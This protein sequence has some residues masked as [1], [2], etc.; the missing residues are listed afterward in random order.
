MAALGVCL[1][2]KGLQ[3]HEADRI[4][5]SNSRKK[6]PL[7]IAR[8]VYTG[9]PLLSTLWTVDFDKHVDGPPIEFF[10]RW[11]RVHVLSVSRW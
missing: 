4:T 2:D 5:L 1:R 10:L 11:Q 8:Q 9:V 6:L 3:T 7:Q